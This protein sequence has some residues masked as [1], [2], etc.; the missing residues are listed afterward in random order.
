MEP[1]LI[2]YLTFAGLAILQAVL[3]IWHTV[4]NRRFSRSR[5]RERHVGRSSAKVTLFAPCKGIDEGL[6]E[7]LRRLLCQ[8]YDHYEVVFIVESDDDPAC[9]VID[10]VMSEHCGVRSRMV[11][12]GLASESGQKVHNLR[13]AASSISADVE[14]LAFVDSDARPRK[15]WLRRMVLRLGDPAVGAV[16]GYRWFAPS[17]S[18]LANDVL[19]S[20]NCSVGLL[21][22]PGGYYAVWGGSWAVRREVFDSLAISRAWRG[23][24]S[25]DLMV[26]RLMHR[27]GMRVEFEPAAMVASP[28]DNTFG[29]MFSFLRRQYIIGK[30]YV[31]WLWIGSLMAA[32]VATGVFWSSMAW[33]AVAVARGS[34]SAWIP[35]G[36]G[37][38]LYALGA[39]R[40]WIRQDLVGTY[41]PELRE[42]LRS[43]RRF[44]IWAGPL[45]GLVNWF[46]LFGA[47]LGRHITWRGTSYRLFPGGKIQ[48]MARDDNEKP[49]II[50]FPRLES[51]AAKSDRSLSWEKVG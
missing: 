8:D 36:V 4:E 34:A 1:T 33:L 24:L 19:Y 27:A 23:T 10:R 30:F 37:L 13:V 9:E 47:L 38:M 25:D 40:G 50:P 39:L 2:V 12:A 29:G 26:T 28:V 21:L 49:T 18:S 16:T 48:M 6:E 42:Q 51:P 17:R 43:A 3:M 20:I 46:G 41:F 22:G 31:P 7:N 45:A 14:I 44:D 35:A 15:E 5:M 32:T 11:V